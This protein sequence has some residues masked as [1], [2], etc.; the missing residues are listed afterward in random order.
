M[1]VLIAQGCLNTRLFLENWVCGSYSVFKN[2]C[3]CVFLFP[4]DTGLG[5][6]HTNL[7]EIESE[8]L[9]VFA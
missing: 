9:F 6:L 3:V 4:S 5:R 2:V 8:H 7:A 1:A